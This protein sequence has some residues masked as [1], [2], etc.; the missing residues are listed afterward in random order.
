MQHRRERTQRAWRGSTSSSVEIEGTCVSKYFDETVRLQSEK[1][2]EWIRE[3]RGDKLQEIAEGVNSAPRLASSSAASFPR[4]NECPGT[5]CSLTEQEDREDSSCQICHR[6]WDKRKDGGEDR[7]AR[8]ERESNSRRREE[9]WQACWC[10]RDQLRA[11]RLAQASAEKLEHTGPA[12]KEKVSLQCHRESSWQVRQS[13]L[14]QKEQSSQSKVP[15]REGE[16]VKVSKSCTLARKRGIRARAWSGKSG[17][18][19]EGRQIQ[20][21]RRRARKKSVPRRSRKRHERVSGRKSS[22]GRSAESWFHSKSGQTWN[23]KRGWKT[24]SPAVKWVKVTRRGGREPL[25]KRRGIGGDKRQLVM[26]RLAARW[27]HSNLVTLV[28]L[29]KGNHPGEAY[30]RRD[31]RKKSFMQNREGLLRGAPWGSRDTVQGLETWGKTWPSA[32]IHA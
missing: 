17:L 14:C 12:E 24:K 27:R 18:H 10:Y 8:T 29:R 20:W 11:C 32:K 23:R 22:P 3:I 31:R 28:S 16:R 4:R 13:R 9:K 2:E 15:D 5:H 19:S 26:A 30:V 21:S 1:R 7:V 6:V 25:E